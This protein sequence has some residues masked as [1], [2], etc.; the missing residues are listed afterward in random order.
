MRWIIHFSI[1][2]NMR[3]LLIT[4]LIAIA[5]AK[6]QPH[7]DPIKTHVPL[8]YKVNVEDSPLK[9]WAPIVRDYKEPIQKLIDYISQRPFPKTFFREVQWFA[10]NEYIHQD[11]IA[12]VDAIATLSGHPF[13][14]VLFA[15]FIYEFSTVGACSGVLVRTD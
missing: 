11:F 14:K 3:G 7:P 4:C 5:L 15:N 6:P 8:K 1:I 9:R 13:E 10:R 12:E 2:F